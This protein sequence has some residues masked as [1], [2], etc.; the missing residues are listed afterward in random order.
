[1]AVQSKKKN[2][3]DIAERMLL[4][5]KAFRQDCLGGNLALDQYKTS[6]CKSLRE[7]DKNIFETFGR[8][9]RAFVSPR[10]LLWERRKLIALQIE[11]LSLKSLVD[12]FD[13]YIMTSGKNCRQLRI[14]V[15]RGS[16]TDDHMG[17]EKSALCL[18]SVNDWKANQPVI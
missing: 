7:P 13:K 9:R 2:A 16:K 10:D 4:F 1:M 17:K 5:L 3:R 12:F 14:Y 6:L 15:H 8:L 18:A 11:K